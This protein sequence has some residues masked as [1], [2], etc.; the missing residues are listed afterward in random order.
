MAA[1]KSD[2]PATGAAPSAV[3]WYDMHAQ[4]LADGY[5]GLDAA[6]THPKLFAL[7]R[8]SAPLRVLDIG[9]GSGR[10]AAALA[11]LGHSVTAVDPSRKMLRLARALHA[12]RDVAWKRDALPDLASLTGPYDLIL[13]SGV[14]MHVT[15]GDRQRAFERL[16]AL[17]APAGQIYITLRRGPEDPARA[18]WPT[19]VAEISDFAAGH[20]ME[21]T[22]LGRRPDLLGRD[23]V[24]W[25]NLLVRK[26]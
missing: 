17:A 26:P 9:A 21:M 2:Q 12:D 14:W 23:D 4:Q 18:M 24:D 1:L 13:L 11:A 19:S 7:V 15:P 6:L 8:N 10:D 25:Q 16:H 20:G 3:A 22:D 5:E